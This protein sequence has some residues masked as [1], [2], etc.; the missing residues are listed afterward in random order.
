MSFRHSFKLGLGCLLLMGVLSASGMAIAESVNGASPHTLAQNSGSPPSNSNVSERASRALSQ[1]AQRD[2]AAR[3]NVPA[4]EIQILEVTAQ[5]WP[6]QCLGLARPNERCMGGEVRGYRIQLASSQQQWAYRS[7]RTGRRLVMEP[8]A[9]GAD[10]GSGDF[11]VETSRRLLETVSN[12]TGQSIRQLKILEV[13]G[14]VWNGCL[15]IFEPDRFCT[16]IA[17][18]GFRTLISDGQ[19]VWVYHLSEEGSQIAQNAT[20]SGAQLPLRVLF[21]PVDNPPPAIAETVVFQSQLSGDFAGSVSRVFLTT[22][23]HIYRE[24]TRPPGGG[25]PTRELIKTLSP[26]ALARF[27]TQLQQQRFPNFNGLRYVT[28]AVF[29]DYPTTSLQAPGIGVDYIDLEIDKLPADLKAIIATWESL[30]Q[31][32]SGG[33]YRR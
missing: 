8:V 31:P 9:G 13:Q 2:L 17:I 29:A 10:F 3:L 7:D 5:T 14:A 25:T 18:A 28:E 12:D 20:A 30:I 24:Q 19:Q 1:K 15:G 21:T 4:R 23:G 16:E 22:D 32:G 26:E 33:A 6:D 27:Q 11:S